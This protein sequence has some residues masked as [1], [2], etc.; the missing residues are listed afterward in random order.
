[1]IAFTPLLQIIAFGMLAI[2]LALFV[3]RVIRGP[4]VLDR[5]MC[6]EGVVMTVICIMAV[7][8]ITLGSGFFFDAILV[9]SIVGF[10]SSVIIAKYL[11]VGD[12]ID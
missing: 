1:M 4:H 7:W 12:I 11:E 2:T 9:L 3:H 5:A 10:I 6:V 8:N